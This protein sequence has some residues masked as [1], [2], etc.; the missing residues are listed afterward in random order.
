MQ[1]QKKNLN[2]THSY[3]LKNLNLDHSILSNSKLGVPVRKI[4]VGLSP[5][6]DSKK[7]IPSTILINL[8]SIKKN[9]RQFKLEDD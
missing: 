7:F 2:T 5:I 8:S 6:V 3:S 1:C 9:E 4:G